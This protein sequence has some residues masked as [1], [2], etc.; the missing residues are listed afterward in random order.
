MKDF[1]NTLRNITNSSRP[2]LEKKLK[3]E[4]IAAEVM[5]AHEKYEKFKNSMLNEALE[6]K[7]RFTTD[8]FKFKHYPY[9]CMWAAQDGLF[10]AITKIEGIEYLTFAWGEY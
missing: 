9:F 6:G 5:A 1:A 2:Q 7:Y 8:D 10:I 4:E 3:D